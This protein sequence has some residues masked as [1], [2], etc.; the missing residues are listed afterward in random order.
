[1]K[2]WRDKIMREEMIDDVSVE[3]AAETSTSQE[4]KLYAGKFKT[5]DELEKGYKNAAAVY[6]ANR[7]LET[8][9]KEITEVPDDYIVPEHVKTLN[10]SDI[11]S[12]KSLVRNAGLSQKMFEKIVSDAEEQSAQRRTQEQEQLLNIGEENLQLL[13]DYV[14]RNYSENVA[15]KV[16]TAIVSDPE[17][18]KEALADRERK[19]NSSAPGLSRPSGV[20]KAITK[21]DLVALQKEAYARPNDLALRDRVI[22]LTEEY[23]KQKTSSFV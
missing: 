6:E 8:S 20:A 3:Q 12:I 9:L 23:A 13:S 22:K 5:V 11:N 19:L 21:D 14:G 4:E 17:A 2:N 10:E 16:L 18:V 15:K 7:K 1:M